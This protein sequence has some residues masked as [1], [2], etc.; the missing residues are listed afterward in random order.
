VL[1]WLHP[2]HNGEAFGLAG[3]VLACVAGLLPLLLMVTGVQRW[4][5]RRRA[6]RARSAALTMSLDP[7]PPQP[8]GLQA[9]NLPR[10]P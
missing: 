7:T 4:A 8:A 2:L 1:A 6:G 10:L 5:D 9:P 3:R